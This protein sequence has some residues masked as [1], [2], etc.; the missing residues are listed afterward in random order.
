MPRL[1]KL[2]DINKIKKLLKSFQGET[3]DDKKIVK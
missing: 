3:G 1:G 2:I